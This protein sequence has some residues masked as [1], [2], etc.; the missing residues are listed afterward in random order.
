M[1]PLLAPWLIAMMG[2]LAITQSQAR[3][4]ETDI[5]QVCPP[6]TSLPK[7]SLTKSACDTRNLHTAMRRVKDQGVL[8]LMPGRY[9][10]CMVITKNHLTIEGEGAQ[11]VNKACKGKAAIVLYD[12]TAVIRHL[13]CRNIK[14][15]GENGSCV[16]FHGGELTLE[17]VHFSDSQSG[18]LGG[19]GILR[20]NGSV[21]ERNGYGG[22]A[23]QVYFSGAQA[24]LYIR[25][26]KFLSATGEGHGIKS[27]ARR[28]VL[29]N[30]VIDG[31]GGKMSRNIDAYN[32]GE[33]VIENSTLRK[34]PSDA[35]QEIIGYDYESRVEH[36]VNRIVLRNNVFDCG[37]GA[38]VLAGTNSLR[39]AQIV[40]ENN[41]FL[42]NCH[43]IP[44]SSGI[45]TKP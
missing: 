5:L 22:Q 23:H 3:S 28:L 13:A 7:T 25:D 19:D 42:G 9:P 15:A 34:D 30:V 29:D 39:G 37:M 43:A 38:Y 35:N 10:E 16:R 44:K 26:S 41:R 2:V 4:G 20:I 27:G 18:L 24:E 36:K 33:L 11:L 21:F 31:A 45:P 32:G 8:Q 12:H 1:I 40:A 14:V 17:N 6:K